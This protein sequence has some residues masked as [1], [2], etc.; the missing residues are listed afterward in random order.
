MGGEAIETSEPQDDYTNEPHKQQKFDCSR[1]GWDSEPKRRDFY[2][3]KAI[4]VKSHHWSANS[5]LVE[6]NTRMN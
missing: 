1:I 5:A 6:A 3:E 4:N 2:I